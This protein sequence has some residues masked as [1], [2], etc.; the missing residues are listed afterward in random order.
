MRFLLFLLTF[1]VFA[2]NFQNNYRLM[3]YDNHKHLIKIQT[4]EDSKPLIYST[5]PINNVNTIIIS[6]K[7]FD[8]FLKDFKL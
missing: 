6:E 8:R 2:D 1:N 3:L 5:K 7:Q 4:N